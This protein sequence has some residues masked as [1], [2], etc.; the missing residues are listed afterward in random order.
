MCAT[1]CTW[2]WLD[3]WATGLRLVLCSVFW[4][5]VPR[6]RVRVGA[7]SVLPSLAVSS[8]AGAFRCVHIAFAPPPLRLHLLFFTC[9][10][11]H[12]E[13]LRS[14]ARGRRTWALV[15]T[16]G[17]GVGPVVA[18]VCV[19]AC[20]HVCVCC[21]GQPQFFFS[22]FPFLPPFSRCRRVATPSSCPFPLPPSTAP[23]LAFLLLGS[24]FPRLWAPPLAAT[25]A[26]RSV[27]PLG[28]SHREAS[29]PPLS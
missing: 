17:L 29:P 25:G 9:T 28:L 8:M 11:C 23:L 18:C 3:V 21:A 24:G 26:R 10:G 12:F 22:L 14:T 1:P 15:P 20:V 6:L 13:T 7:V 16:R 5:G 19:R 4:C 27:H 2:T